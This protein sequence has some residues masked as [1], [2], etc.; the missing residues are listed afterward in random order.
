MPDR[1]RAPHVVVVD[2]KIAMAEM[3]ADGLVDRG[4]S[5]VAVA[6]GAQA[7]AQIEAEPVDA[8]VTDLRMPGMDGVELLAAARRAAPDLPVIVMTAYGA[9]DTA[10][11]S[12]RRGAYHYL[13]K[14]FKLDELIVY[15]SRALDEANLRRETRTLRRSLQGQAPRDRIVA[16]SASMRAALDVIERVCGSDVPVLLT[17]P[18]GA[19]KGLLA[20]HLHAES[21][22]ANGS[23]VTVNCA[24][25]PEPLLE[26]ELFGHAKG[27]FTGASTRRPGLFAEA[28]GGTLFLDEIGEM[29]PPLQAKL[30]DVIERRVV[31]PL[32]SV[33]ELSV[34]VRIVA[35]THRDLRRRVAEGLFREDLLYRLDV[36]AVRVPPLRERRED[37][38][39]LL[40]RFLSEAR[41][42]HPSACVQRLSPACMTQLLDYPWPGNVRELAHTVERLVLLGRTPE[43]QPPD[44]ALPHPVLADTPAPEFAGPVLTL[45]E[46]QQRYV[47]W[48]L[49]E[50]GGNK[51]RAAERL[52]IDVKTLTKYLL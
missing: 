4:F 17:G 39:E 42:R 6:T 3:L 11:E 52:G 43:A 32:G 25:L 7:L 51:T 31:R 36:V 22:R 24:A 12:I 2:D 33:K 48:A 21:G 28:E 15:L 34:D 38:P 9:V 50:L 16:R 20:R 18:T 44:A 14:P 5:A 41:T 13:T 19:G 1:A 8:L 27:A 46:L 49:V 29:A 35:A 40:E 37:I 26:S 23:F 30:L 47:R 45:R 10:I